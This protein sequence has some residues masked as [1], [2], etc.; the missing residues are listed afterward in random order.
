MNAR[1]HSSRITPTARNN[2]GTVL[3]DQ[4]KLTEAAACYERTL[5]L[6][7]DYPDAHNNLGTVLRDQG[8]LTEAVA[9]FERAL[10]LKPDYAEAN[11]NLGNVLQR[12]GQADRS[13]GVL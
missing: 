12:S 13:D 2:L 10:A 3:R 7:P 1:S 6:K 11:N 9:C 4:G 5:A 8:K